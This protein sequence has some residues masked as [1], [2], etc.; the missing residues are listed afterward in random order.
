MQ[1][2]T[3]FLKKVPQAFRVSEANVTE[4]EKGYAFFD[5]NGTPIEEGKY[6]RFS[7]DI[8]LPMQKK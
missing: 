3:D 5:L 8:L 7:V 2:L 1:E 4:I 6:L